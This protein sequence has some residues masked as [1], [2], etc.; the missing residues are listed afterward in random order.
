MSSCQ[1]S[2]LQTLSSFKHVIEQ[3]I[4]EELQT[5]EASEPGQLLQSEDLT[6]GSRIELVKGIKNSKVSHH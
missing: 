1:Q 6:L 4:E 3:D 5:M 2:D